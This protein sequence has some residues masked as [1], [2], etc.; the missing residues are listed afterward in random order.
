M[1]TIEGITTE[2]D[3]ASG[4]DD[5]TARGR[6]AGD[7]QIACDQFII[8]QIILKILVRAVWDLD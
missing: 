4:L 7:Q 6:L 3:R 5:G 2:E 8:P 1:V